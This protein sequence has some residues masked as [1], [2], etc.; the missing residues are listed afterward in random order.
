MDVDNTSISRIIV[1]SDHAG[2]RLKER[3]LQVLVAKGFVVV[4]VGVF[5]DLPADYPEIASKVAAKVKADKSA[6]GILVCGSGTGMAIVANRFKG[7]R[8]VAAYDAFT[9]R[10]SRID[11]DANV[12][13]LRSRSFPVKRSES[14]MLLW[15]RTPFSGL[16]RHRKRIG[17]LE[18]RG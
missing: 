10:S 17:Q 6:K 4:D 2:F 3:L 7:I 15:L 16:A 8:A 12:L 13:C 5:D 9:A 14:I 18:A 11:N 1:G